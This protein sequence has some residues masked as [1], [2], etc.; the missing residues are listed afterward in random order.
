MALCSSRRFTMD[1]SVLGVLWATD[2]K[3]TVRAGDSEP[4]TVLNS[5]SRLLALGKPDKHGGLNPVDSVVLTADRGY[6]LWINPRG[7]IEVKFRYGRSGENFNCFI[8]P[9]HQGVTIYELCGTYR[10]EMVVDG[11]QPLSKNTNPH[12]VKPTGVRRRENNFEFRSRNSEV[13]LVLETVRDSPPQQAFK[14]NY[15]LTL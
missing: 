6:L 7:S 5:P 13:R 10:K 9:Q 11:R 4:V 14:F 12:H 2:T 15:V 1:L 3:I 8:D